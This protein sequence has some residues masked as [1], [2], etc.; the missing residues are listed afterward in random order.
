MFGEI[1]LAQRLPFCSP[2]IL[3]QVELPTLLPGPPALPAVACFDL[4]H[5]TVQSPCAEQ[6]CLISSGDFMLHSS[7]AFSSQKW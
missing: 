2:R 5:G 6:W 4:Q 7:S 3:S 1:V